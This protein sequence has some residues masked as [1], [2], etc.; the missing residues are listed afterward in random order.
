MNPLLAATLAGALL[1]AGVWA[2]L[3]AWLVPARPRL[4]DA[5]DLLDGR[6]SAA[7]LP[8]TGIDRLGG[9]LRTTL[10][11]PV[12]DVTQRR[13]RLVGRSIERHDSYKALG[14]LIGFLSPLV[15]GA[16]G[17][18]T[19]G[20]SFELPAASAPVLGAFGF[21]L[22]DLQLGRQEDSLA[23]DAT[24]SLLTFFDLVTL[25]R[26][27]NRSASQAMRAAAE[28]SD[29]AV[30]SAIRDAL[31]RA[32]LEQ[33]P[34]Y[35]ELQRLS[36]EL[37]LPALADIAD[38]MALDEAGA[39]L[40]DAL[41]ARVRELRDAHLTRARIQASAISERMAFLMVIPSMVF[42]LFFLIPPVLRLLSE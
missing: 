10:R 29:V 16:V 20:A 38:V 12:S 31:E 27:A 26:L 21:L 11:R 3:G 22:P 4:A 36:G 14:A 35:P 2:L 39:S 32:R 41:R 23:E 7:A 40:A 18:F 24:E 37:E 34:P 28:L 6:E 5:L 33:R 42:A 17:Y 8:A 25:E 13:L 1:A 9:W 19:I 15:A 30:F